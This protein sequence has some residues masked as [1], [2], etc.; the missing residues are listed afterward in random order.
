MRVRILQA[1]E[2]IP[3]ATPAPV[4]ASAP[5]ADA[6]T[7]SETIVRAAASTGTC[8]GSSGKVYT[9]RRL[10]PLDRM[11]IAKALGGELMANP[12]YASYALV[13]ASVS[14]IDAERLAMPHSARTAE[15]LVTRIGEDW[16]ALNAAMRDAFNPPAPVD[17]GDD[18]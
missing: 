2:A 13:A 18:D 6:P 1:G 17:V 11:L 3:T 15:A 10:G 9:F 8:M 7:P 14:Q 16:D 4:A 5:T 12:I